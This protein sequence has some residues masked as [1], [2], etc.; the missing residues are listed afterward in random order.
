MAS[1]LHLKFV[2]VLFIILNNNVLKILNHMFM[3][4][5]IRLSKR[6]YLVR[7]VLIVSAVQ[8]GRLL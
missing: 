7:G 4:M 5:F 1:G 8:G 6:D 3:F 2:T